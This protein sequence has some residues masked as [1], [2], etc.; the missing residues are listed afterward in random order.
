MVRVGLPR[1]KSAKDLGWT[2]SKETAVLT[3]LLEE[4]SFPSRGVSAG[5]K[6]AAEVFGA[7]D[8]P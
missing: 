4:T 7:S 2:R 1:E 8:V 5:R 3:T 6:D